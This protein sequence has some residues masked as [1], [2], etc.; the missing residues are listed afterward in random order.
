MPAGQFFVASLASP[1]DRLPEAIVVDRFQQIV[2]RIGVESL[3]R[4][5]IIGGYEDHDRHVAARE[6]LQHIEAVDSGHLYVQEDNVRR[7]R[8]NRVDCLA[9]VPAF[10]TNLYVVELLQP[11]LQTASRQFLIVNDQRF[12]HGLSRMEY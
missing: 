7:L 12:E 1:L 3:E 6:S 9:A 11:N 5:L 8:P 2:E 4:E 10:S